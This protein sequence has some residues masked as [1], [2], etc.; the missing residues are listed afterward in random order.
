VRAPAVDDNRVYTAIAKYGKGQTTDDLG[1]AVELLFER[2]L[3]PRLPAMAT[4]VSNDFRTQRLYT[5][6]VDML[7][8]QHQARTGKCAHFA[9]KHDDACHHPHV[10]GSPGV[11]LQPASMTGSSVV[12]VECKASST[13]CCCMCCRG[14]SK[15]CTA[16][17]A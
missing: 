1:V 15:H 4:L 6:E 10:G 2:N 16:G 9:M 8:K 14:C 7:F 13:E 3:I 12:S 5:E 17:T 11:H